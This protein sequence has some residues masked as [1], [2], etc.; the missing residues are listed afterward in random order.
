MGSKDS[1]SSDSVLL[2]ESSDGSSGSACRACAGGM[3]VPR[4]AGRAGA[5]SAA[6]AEGA[7]SSLSAGSWAALGMAV[8]RRPPPASHVTRDPVEAAVLSSVVASSSAH[9]TPLAG[10]SGADGAAR[11]A[12]VGSRGRPESPGESAA[13]GPAAESR[14]SG[15]ASSSLL[16]WPAKAT[17]AA[18]S[19]SDS[20]SDKRR[21]GN[22]VPRRRVPGP[23]SVSTNCT[24]A[25]L[26]S[27]H[28]AATGA[29]WGSSGGVRSSRYAGK[30]RCL[31]SACCLLPPFGPSPSLVL[32]TG[33]SST[34]S[35]T[36]S[37]TDPFGCGC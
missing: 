29:S 20:L 25:A 24:V 31:R 4:R 18:M 7:S 10:E 11:A 30:L 13:E 8:P 37:T 5:S 14:T 2:A 26:S 6:G 1:S 36:S 35:L 12:D 15:A 9:R 22:I 23:R 27:C 34:I 3:A 17:A 16:S 32:E 19:S 21:L 28:S 33:G